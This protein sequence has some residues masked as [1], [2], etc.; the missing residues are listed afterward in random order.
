[1]SATAALAARAVA[2]ALLGVLSLGCD[3][4]TKEGFGSLCQHYFNLRQQGV[5]REAA[6]RQLKEARLAPPGN[7]AHWG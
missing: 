6:L 3:D 5:G 2:L 7:H 4:V 1:M